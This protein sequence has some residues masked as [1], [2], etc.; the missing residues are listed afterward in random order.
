MVHTSSA[1]FPDGIIR[2]HVDYISLSNVYRNCF[3]ALKIYPAIDI[4][5]DHN[6]LLGVLK[7]RMKNIEETVNKA[8][9]AN[10]LRSPSKNR[11]TR[12]VSWEV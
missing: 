9:N 3:T 11:D 6:L 10:T 5:S 12:K 2:N 1:D 8:S 7:V 4:D